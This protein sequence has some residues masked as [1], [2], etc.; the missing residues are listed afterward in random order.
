MSAWFGADKQPF[1]YL[2]PAVS[3]DNLGKARPKKG[4]KIPNKMLREL[5]AG[6]YK[7]CVALEG[8][9]KVGKTTVLQLMGNTIYATVPCKIPNHI[10]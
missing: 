7:A 5:A 9:A 2:K 10:E 4:K 1:L 8:P 6:Q 3:D